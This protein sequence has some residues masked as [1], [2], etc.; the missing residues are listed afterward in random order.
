MPDAPGH[1]L[2]QDNVIAPMILLLIRL[3]SLF[4]PFSLSSIYLWKT[5]RNDTRTIMPYF[6]VD[7]TD[8]SLEYTEYEFTYVQRNYIRQEYFRFSSFNNSKVLGYV[9]GRFVYK[10]I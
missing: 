5:F 1:P 2:S 10:H 8:R 9:I 6:R 7:R 3:S 4:P